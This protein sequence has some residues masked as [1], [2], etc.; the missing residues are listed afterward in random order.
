MSFF[1]R[2]FGWM[3]AESNAA[4][5]S[6]E[7]PIKMTDQGIRDLKKDLD[8]S[9]QGLAQVKAISIRTR[10]EYEQHKQAASDWERKAVLLLQKANSGQ[11]DVTEAD[12][13]ATEALSKKE[14]A[15]QAALTHEKMVTQNET[16]VT[17]MEQNVQRLKSQISQ[18]ENEAKTLK[19]RAKVSE[20]SSKINK[21]LAN[22][23]SSSTVA[24]LERMK[25]KVE[26]K[27]ALAESYGD[28][29]DANVSID[30]EIN[31]AIGPGGG[32]SSLALDQ[33]KE[34]M[35]LGSGEGAGASSSN[36]ATPP[37]EESDLDKLKNQLKNNQ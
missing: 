16:Q 9:L 30:D 1:K 14:Q 24:M 3:S 34:K 2:I 13:L 32:T 27:E 11:L 29:A 8:Q 22:I 20:A 36:S 5:D 17:K 18:W 19:A 6:L 7:D 31:K 28:I 15:A 25:N 37:Q 10:K 26:E 21:Q 4:L 23:D 33:L 35:R 12:R